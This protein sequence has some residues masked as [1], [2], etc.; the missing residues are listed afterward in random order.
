MKEEKNNGDIYVVEGNILLGTTS[1]ISEE[2]T[3]N[4]PENVTMIADPGD[5]NIS[6]IEIPEIVH[7]I[8]S[9]V[10]TS[11]SNLEE[12]VLLDSVTYME[13]LWHL[14]RKV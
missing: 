3:L 7:M 5:T 4:I 9:N 12:L 1:K 13:I 14:K 10:F 8:G 11:C 6:K 2:T